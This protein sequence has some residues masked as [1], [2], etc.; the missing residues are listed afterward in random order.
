MKKV[1]K[2]KKFIQEQT[3]RVL[4]MCVRSQCSI[5]KHQD[6]AD[7][8]SGSCIYML[9][10]HPESETVKKQHKINIKIS[11]Q[12]VPKIR[13]NNQ[14]LNTLPKLHVNSFHSIFACFIFHVFRTKGCAVFAHLCKTEKQADSSN[15][16]QSVVSIGLDY[17]WT[18]FTCF[19]FETG[20]KSQRRQTCSRE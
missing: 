16:M 14:N 3:F 19:I 4:N 7:N 20:L 13:K 6:F 2:D 5:W 17:I 12:P 15:K 10:R 11:S 1:I 8:L 18:W 9:A